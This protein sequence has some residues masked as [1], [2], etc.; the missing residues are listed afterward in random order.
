MWV[1]SSVD[2]IRRAITDGLAESPWLDAKRELGSTA[3]A[4]KDVAAMA[5]DGGVLIYGVGEN[6][7]GQLDE[8]CPL[9]DLS[10]VEERISNAVRDLVHNPPSVHVSLLEE[11]PGST[12]GCL[13]VVVPRS[14]LAPHMVEGRRGGRYY[15]RVGTTTHRLT[16]SQVDQLLTRRSSLLRDATTA[17]VEAA[18]W[19]GVA[20]SDQ[21]DARGIVVV[22]VEPQVPS[23]ALANR[24]AGGNP[25]TGYLPEVFAEVA[26]GAGGQYVRDLAETTRVG[27]WQIGIE[28]YVTQQASESIPSEY[29]IEVEVGRDGRIITRAGGAVTTMSLAAVQTEPRPWC[30]EW[31]IAVIVEATLAAA[32]RIFRDAGEFGQVRCSVRVDGLLGA[33]SLVLENARRT[34]ASRLSLFDQP[35]MFEDEYHR[36]IETL[37]PEIVDNR[38][39]VARLLLHDLFEALAQGTYPDGLDPLASH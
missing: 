11:F 28:R 8:I 7:A 35:R 16:G 30:N 13:V 14:P 22:L 12:T 39:Q 2:E 32:G 26:A 4:A 38:R 17:L 6:A 23:G 3:E 18:R 37:V 9:E 24:A 21:E 5:N 33:G 19:R 27:Y 31:R 29:R 15:G 34:G 20:P 10:R 36:H 25:V 1:P